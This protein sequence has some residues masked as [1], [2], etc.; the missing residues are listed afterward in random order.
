MRLVHA[1]LSVPS[2]ELNTEV[3]V[4]MKWQTGPHSRDRS[5][6]WKRKTF[7]NTVL[8]LRITKNIPCHQWLMEMGICFTAHRCH[9]VGTAFIIRTATFWHHSNSQTHWQAYLFS[10]QLPWQRTEKTNSQLQLQSWSFLF[11]F[12]PFPFIPHGVFFPPRE[13]I[14]AAIN[15]I[16]SIGNRF[17]QLLPHTQ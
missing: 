10:I 4:L 15:Y 13:M 8:H 9:I 16:H 2:A 3:T 1:K 12:S 6:S 14:A 17:I 5:N 7:L 11:S